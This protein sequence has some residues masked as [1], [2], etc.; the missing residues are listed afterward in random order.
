MKTFA[1]LKARFPRLLPASA[2][3][4][5]GLGLGLAGHRAMAE[6]DGDSCCYPG[7]PCCQPGADC[8]LKHAPQK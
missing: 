5:L 3:A 6:E 4:L 2:A 8:C 7:S 1:D